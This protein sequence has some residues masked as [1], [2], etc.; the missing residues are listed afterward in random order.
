MNDIAKAVQIL[1]DGGIV[2]FPT[3]TAFG[4]GCRIDDENA[5]KRLF[6]LRKSPETKA[7]PV[8]VSDLSM[9]QE[10]LEPVPQEVIE[11]LVKAHWPG[12]L[13]IVLKSKTDKVPSL[14]RGGTDTLGVR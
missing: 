14:V 1:K 12:A 3:D 8:L 2:I 6:T 9:A 13:T 11:K 5:V 7:V 10:Y 4:I